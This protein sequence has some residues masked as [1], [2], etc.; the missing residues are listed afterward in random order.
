MLVTPFAPAADGRHGG[1]RAVH[2]LVG[3]LATRHEVTLVH[4]DRDAI[5]PLVAARCAAVYAVPVPNPGRWAL[6]RQRAGALARG[7]S[8][9]AAASA[10]G[11]LARRVRELAAAL[12]PD[13]VQVEFAFLGD[14]LAGVHGPL[15]VLTVHDPAATLHETLPLRRGGLPL[16]HRLD[17]RVALREERRALALAD[18]A[19]VFTDRDRLLLERAAPLETRLATIPL[20][21]S[22]PE[23]ASD[24]VGASPPTVL[25]VGG[26]LHPPNVHAALALAR[27]IFPAVRAEHPEARLELVGSAPPGELLA[28]ADG[29][30]SVAGDVES[31]DPYLDR[32]AVVVAPISSGGGMRIKVLEALAAGKAVVASSRAAEGLTAL[33]NRDLIVADGVRETADAISSLLADEDARRTLAEHARRWALRELSWRALADRYDELYASAPRR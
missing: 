9:K 15:R 24:P 23:E 12:D 25:F 22:V 13:V 33:P 27:D 18:V 19:V 17:A 20:G 32:A 11:E 2:G 1:A 30:V 6:R 31:V 3:E 29:P 21:W 5:D 26:F 7:H 14:V 8:L 4:L 10:V 16:V 28:L